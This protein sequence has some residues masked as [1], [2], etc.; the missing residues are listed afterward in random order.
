MR[1]I[2]TGASRHSS[3]EF[4]DLE[5]L[6]SIH[7]PSWDRCSHDHEAGDRALDFHRRASVLIHC[8]ARSGG[9]N[10]TLWLWWSSAPGRC[11]RDRLDH[12]ALDLHVAKMAVGK[13]GDDRRFR[14][15]GSA[16]LLQRRVPAPRLTHGMF[17]S[18]ERREL[19]AA[20]LCCRSAFAGAPGHFESLDQAFE[21]RCV[22]DVYRSPG[23]SF[24]SGLGSGSSGPGPFRCMV[25]A[26]AFAAYMA[27]SARWNGSRN[28]CWSRCRLGLGLNCRAGSPTPPANSYVSDFPW[29]VWRAQRRRPTEKS[30]G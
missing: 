18:C 25:A 12:T 6:V 13:L 23:Q 3:V 9:R 27:R 2:L 26:G 8:V 30:Y 11:H 20:R 17:C 22:R 1:C 10:E 7:G 15:A 16:F 28:C 29:L 24:C 5:V 21:P 19:H 14:S 4:K